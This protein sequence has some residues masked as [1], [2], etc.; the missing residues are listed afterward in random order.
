MTEKSS[1]ALRVAEALPKDVGRGIARLDPVDM[2]RLGAVI[3]DIVE[4][5]GKRRTVARLM[6][7]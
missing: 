3:G 2:E 7:A 1:L 5:T 4:L 6:P